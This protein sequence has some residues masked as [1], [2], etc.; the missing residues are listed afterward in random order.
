MKAISHL[1]HILNFNWQ[2]TKH[3]LLWNAEHT[4]EYKYKTCWFEFWQPSDWTKG[5]G[6]CQILSYRTIQKAESCFG[7]MYGSI[8]ATRHVCKGHINRETRDA[9]FSLRRALSQTDSN[10]VTSQPAAPKSTPAW[11]Q[12]MGD[13]R[14]LFC[15]QTPPIQAQ[16]FVNA[17]SPMIHACTN[18]FRLTSGKVFNYCINWSKLFFVF[19]IADIQ[20]ENDALHICW[21]CCKNT[22]IQ[23]GWHAKEQSIVAWL[24]VMPR[25]LDALLKSIHTELYFLHSII[26]C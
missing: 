6:K 9:L 24:W 18:N 11:T 1:T 12:K 10:L 26:L 15:S 13:G 4:D 25:Y 23:L 16:L 22:S 20:E 14:W 2:N 3:T 21:L 19:S 17:G 7:K 8:P 5:L